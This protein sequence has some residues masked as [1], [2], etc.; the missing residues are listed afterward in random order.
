MRWFTIS[1]KGGTPLAILLCTT[2]RWESVF[3]RPARR[4]GSYAYHYNEIL[5]LFNSIYQSG[6]FSLQTW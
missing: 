6:R 4:T 2:R 1:C 5:C 3:P